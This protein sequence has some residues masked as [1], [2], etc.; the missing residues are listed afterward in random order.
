M[1]KLT[2]LGLL[3]LTVGSAFGQQQALYSQYMFNPFAINPAYAGSRNALSGV[4]DIRSQWAGMDGAPKTASL[5]IHS[6]LKGNKMALG[7]NLAQDNIGPT[8]STS[9]YAT[10][11]YHLKMPVGKLSFGLRGGLVSTTFDFNQLNYNEAGEAAVNLGAQSDLTPSMDFGVYYYA[12]QLFV[13]GS[14]SHLATSEMVFQSDTL[15]SS[16]ELRPHVMFAAGYAF[17]VGP[18]VVLR[19][20]IHTKHVFT[21]SSDF[22]DSSMGIPSNVDATISALF[23]Q[24]FWFGLSYRHGSAI[25]IITEYNIT[26]YLRIGYSYDMVTNAL[27]SYTLGSHE[28]LI[29]F[30]VS[31]KK[32]KVISPRYM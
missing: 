1:K 31:L 2:I 7:F 26:D 15:T 18:D 30:D 24:T 6:P 10:Y 13:G 9:A 28:L 21:E 22:G 5:A 3:L 20:T 23:K 17:K 29:G 8:Q 14:V 32:D 25:G 11:A 16:F 27:K 4:L 12:N 19:P